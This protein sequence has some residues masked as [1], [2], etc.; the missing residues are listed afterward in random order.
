MIATA[1]ARC[2]HLGLEPVEGRALRSRTGYLAGSDQA[3][4]ADLRWGF[5]DAD[6]VWAVRGG[7]GNLRTLD[8]VDLDPVRERPVPFIGF[9]DNTVVHMALHHR[10]ITSF[11][12]PHGGYEHFTDTTETV[13]RSVLW[14][15][16]APGVLPL[17]PDAEP[18][19]VV[20]GVAEG[21]LMGGNLAILAAT[22]GTPYQPSARGAILF[23]EDVGEPAYK[24]DRMLTQLRLAGVLDGVAGM[25][26]G[27]FRG[28]E[29]SNHEM[30]AVFEDRVGSLGVP[31]LAGLPFGHGVENWTLP[32][33]VPAR[34]DAAAGTLEILESAVIATE[35][36]VV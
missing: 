25:A 36:E 17:P 7:Y 5:E 20:S 30:R 6:A 23:L 21:R 29:T 4:A 19:P 12:G 1:V 34:L 3:R 31:V 26:V 27:D 9:S 2:H 8:R 33:G 28:G 18:E 22:C 16:A 13:F 24:V 15:G 10:G 32:L 35:G 14:S 11:H